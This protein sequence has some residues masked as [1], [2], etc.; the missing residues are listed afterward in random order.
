MKLKNIFIK[1]F[2]QSTV[3]AEPQVDK[4]L[5]VMDRCYAA[6]YGMYAGDAVA[7]PVHWMYD[8]RNLKRDYGSITGY[9]APKDQFQGS[10]MNLSNTGGAGRGSDQGDIVGSVILHGKK[11]Y[12]GRGKSY[13]YH[14]G[15]NAGENTLECHL[16]RLATRQI[17]QDGG[18]VA[19]NY[20][21]SYVEFMQT[22]GS[23]PDTYAATAHRMFF[24]NL[25][26]GKAPNK[27]ADNDKHNVDAI[28]AL[29]IA[30]PVIIH[31]RDA[32]RDERNRKV[33]EAI[34][35]LRNVAKVE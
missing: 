29:T 28:D 7:M 24:A 21:K 16:A 35:S 5:S 2:M 4:T 14:V 26:A 20:L 19:E 32:S 3:L 8:L 1:L 10:I 9:V 31:Y 33:M 13:H 27:C 17:S 34:R 23:H 6:L 12:W 22:P 18:F 11:K 25:V 30:V 15:M